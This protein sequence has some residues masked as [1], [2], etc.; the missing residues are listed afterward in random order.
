MITPESFTYGEPPQ[1]TPPGIYAALQC[2]DVQEGIS[3]GALNWDGSRWID[4]APAVVAFAGPFASLKEAEDWAY[5]H[6]PDAT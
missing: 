6:D 4:G 1:G 3:P 5:D 2:W